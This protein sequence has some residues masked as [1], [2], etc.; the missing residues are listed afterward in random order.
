MFPMRSPSATS[1]YLGTVKSEGQCQAWLVEP[2]LVP[3]YTME[4]PNWVTLKEK[5][6]TYRLIWA[7][8]WTP[9]SEPC[10]TYA[11]VVNI[12]KVCTH[13][14]LSMKPPEKLLSFLEPHSKAD[15][16]LFIGCRSPGSVLLCCQ[17]AV[18]KTLSLPKSQLIHC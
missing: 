2:L 9:V 15:R 6:P 18:L 1:I 3:R 7:P 12:L 10:D 17:L 16:K 8:T 4:A 11:S 13:V 5:D 14:S